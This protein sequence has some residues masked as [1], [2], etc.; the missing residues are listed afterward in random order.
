MGPGR[1]GGGGGW[2]AGR[3]RRSAADEN[4][5]ARWRAAAGGRALS[6]QPPSLFS[7]TS[8]RRQ[9]RRRPARPA[10]D[11]KQLIVKRS[12]GGPGGRLSARARPAPP[13]AGSRQ[14]QRPIGGLARGMLRPLLPPQIPAQIGRADSWFRLRPSAGRATWPAPSLPRV[15]Q[16]PSPLRTP[17]RVATSTTAPRQPVGL[18]PKR[19]RPL[20]SSSRRRRDQW[21][22]RD[23]RAAHLVWPEQLRRRR[24]CYLRISPGGGRC[25]YEQLER[26]GPGR[27]GNAREWERETTCGAAGS[28]CALESG[29]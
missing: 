6:C 24:N 20:G 29:A 1:G 19:S 7:R 26:A 25:Q 22:P 13:K 17:S 21:G 12:A 4:E 11:A 2:P 27:A 23:V 28:W 9:P 8:S 3:R 10:S 16:L 5:Q 15:G 14:W 18:V